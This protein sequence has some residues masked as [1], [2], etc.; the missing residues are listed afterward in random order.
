MDIRQLTPSDAPAY[1]ALRLRALREHAEAFSSSHQDDALLPLAHT[2]KRLLPGEG[3]RFWGAFDGQRLCGMV[4]LE[5]EQR[6]K[7]RHKAKVVGMYVAPEDAGRGIGRALLDRLV[8]EAR[9][10][11]VEL[12]VLTVT[13]GNKPAT[14]LY[15][16][17]GFHS[18][19]VE[20]DAIRV[21][22][23]SFAKR[24]MYIELKPT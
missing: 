21:D 22:G 24:H 15:Q 9:L 2:E 5:R 16:R 23:R 12:L 19:G 13:D 14:T 10:G 17:A 6:S 20:P 18:F 4:G 11:G 7:T 1:R 3:S 8:A